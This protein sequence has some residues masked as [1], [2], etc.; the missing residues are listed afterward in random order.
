MLGMGF[1]VGGLGVFML[2]ISSSYLVYG[3]FC[4]GF[5][6]IH[7]EFGLPV[8]VGVLVQ[9]EKVK[10]KGRCKF[11]IVLKSNKGELINKI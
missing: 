8:K 5:G 2:L 11:L 9:L 7:L 4:V 1:I 3:S 6:L 10:I